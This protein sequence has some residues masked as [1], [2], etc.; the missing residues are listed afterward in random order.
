MPVDRPWEEL[1]ARQGGMIS[2]R[3]LREVGVDRWRVRNQV[4]A[5][6]WVQRSA[7]VVGTTTGPLSRE[8]LAWLGVLHAGSPSLVGGLSAAELAGLTGWP[9]DEVTVWVPDA[10]E[11]DDLEG[12]RFVRTRRDLRRLR[13]PAPGPPRARIEP[14]VL[15]FGAY[16][17][18]SRTAQGVVAAAVQQ[19][20][21][22]PALLLDW[23]DQLRPLRRAPLYRRVLGDL[24]G[25]AQS[26]AEL[27]VR[28]MCRDAGLALPS[29]QTRRQD[30]AGRWRYT[31]CEWTLPDGTVVV[32]EVDGSFHMEVAHWEDDLARQRRLSRPGRVIVRCTARELRED[33]EQL[34]VDLRSLGVPRAA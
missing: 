9:R 7:L 15:V 19:R 14:A 11:L 27:D 16:Q 32:L 25:G 6:R 34:A 26:L 20:L 23:V 5:G 8:Q 10:L 1:A 31:D 24:A 22:T 12:L 4:R 28:R 18:S 13:H 29:R 30:S 33:R 2:R 3:Q 17:R 21:T